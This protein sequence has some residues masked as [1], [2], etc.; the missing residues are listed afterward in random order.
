MLDPEYFCLPRYLVLRHV[1]VRIMKYAKWILVATG[2]TTIDH[3]VVRYSV[4]QRR[5]QTNEA[6]RRRE[7]K[8]G[9]RP[10]AALLLV[11][12]RSITLFFDQKSIQDE[13]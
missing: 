6:E 8:K 9:E 3:I 12:E 13:R 2:A 4:R 7:P 5:W 1:T 10:V 11:E